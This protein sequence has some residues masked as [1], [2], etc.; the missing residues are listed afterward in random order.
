VNKSWEPLRGAVM[1]KRVKTVTILAV[2]LAATTSMALADNASFVPVQLTIVRCS[3][4]AKSALSLM[5]Q[6][7]APSVL[8]S[9]GWQYKTTI[10]P[11]DVDR[12]NS[13]VQ[14]VSLEVPP[15]LDGVLV[16][17]EHCGGFK[18][19]ATLK[20]VPRHATVVMGHPHIIGGTNCAIAGRLPVSGLV[21]VMRDDTTG[22]FLPVEVDGSA[23]YFVD[24]ELR[25]YTLEIYR[26]AALGYATI[27]IRPQQD[28]QKNDLC[29]T[30]DTLKDV[31]LD[32]LVAGP[33]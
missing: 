11:P 24:A 23:Y 18:A 17:G 21:A 8:E 26:G 4:D 16:K 1:L 5:A 6:T 28:G 3:E 30:F 20:G 19:L 25:G 27:R 2:A 14:T 29:G 15:G 22:V 33:P 31:S 32:D 12:G 7:M 9:N 13:A 10:A